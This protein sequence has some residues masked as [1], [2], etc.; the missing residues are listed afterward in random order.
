MNNHTQIRNVRIEMGPVIPE[1][2][3]KGRSAL[4]KIN[5]YT[6]IVHSKM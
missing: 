6:K 1:E 4:G 2:I 3:L 5:H